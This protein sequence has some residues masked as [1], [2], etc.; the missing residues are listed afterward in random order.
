[1]ADEI[2][3][4]EVPN[5]LRVFHNNQARPMRVKGGRYI[6]RM[7]DMYLDNDGAIIDPVEIQNKIIEAQNKKL[8]ELQEALKEKS[9]FILPDDLVHESDLEK[10]AT[11]A[12]LEGF[13]TKDLASETYQEKGNYQVSGDYLKKTDITWD[14]STLTINN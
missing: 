12:E 9:N 2:T 5:K 10:C 4:P 7:R 6:P 13:L 14:G 3:L 1:M 11:K 8:I